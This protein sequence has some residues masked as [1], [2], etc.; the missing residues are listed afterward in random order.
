MKTLSSLAGTGAEYIP[1]QV[2]VKNGRMH[3]QIQ[4]PEGNRGYGFATDVA[5]P[6]PP[7]QTW[8]NGQPA[9]KKSLAHTGA[10]YVQAQARNYDNGAVHIQISGASLNRPYGATLNARSAALR[11]YIQMAVQ[12][13]AQAAKDEAAAIAKAAAEAAAKAK[14]HAYRPFASLGDREATLA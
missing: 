8:L 12:V 11:D 6:E 13:V 7:F 14:A 10:K 4:G 9:P 5:V 2:R 1:L 3:I